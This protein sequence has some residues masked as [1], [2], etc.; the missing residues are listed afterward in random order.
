MIGQY[1]E[2]NRISYQQASCP[3]SYR[4]KF[5]RFNAPA[6]DIKDNYVSEIQSITQKVKDEGRGIACFIAE[7]LQSCG[8]QVIPPDGYFQDVYR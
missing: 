1:S 5:N 8:G 4:G 2:K 6:D 3:D 7:S